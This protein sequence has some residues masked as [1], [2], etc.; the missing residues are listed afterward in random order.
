MGPA[1]RLATH[2]IISYSFEPVAELDV[3]RSKAMF[4]TASDEAVC[5]HSQVTF[6]FRVSEENSAAV[7]QDVREC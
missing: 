6:G 2:T 1:L 7:D 5:D 3:K 4:A